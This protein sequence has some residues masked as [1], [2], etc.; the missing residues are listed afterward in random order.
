MI[1][2]SPARTLVI[3]PIL[4][5]LTT[6]FAGFETFLYRTV[7][8]KAVLKVVHQNSNFKGTPPRDMAKVHFPN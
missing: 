2:L 3:Q 5:F 7:T 8:R 4:K 6:F 1:T